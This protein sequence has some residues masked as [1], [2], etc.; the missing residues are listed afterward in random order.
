MCGCED[1]EPCDVFRA[2][3]VRA[4][5]PWRCYECERTVQTGELYES[6]V[7]LFEGEWQ[8]LAVCWK[9]HAIRQAWHDVEGCW[10]PYGGLR[11]E[12]FYCLREMRRAPPD[13]RDDDGDLPR[14]TP[15]PDCLQ[16][17]MS[18]RRHF[19]RMGPRRAA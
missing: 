1:G 16:F 13:E 11:D 18:F 4:C 12:V 2:K 17:G 6:S 9:C 8:R 14:L 10:A 15:D 5:R 19:G 3:V 7:S